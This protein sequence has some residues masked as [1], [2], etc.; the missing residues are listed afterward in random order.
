M[1]RFVGGFTV[2]LACVISAGVSAQ[3]TKV[4]TQSTVKADDAKAVTFTGCLQSGTEATSFVLAKAVPVSKTTS[5]ETAT[6]TTGTPTTTTTTTTTYALIPSETVELKSNVGQKVEVTGLVIPAATS[7]DDDAKIKAET[8]TKIENEK[9]PD[10][11][12]KE[13]AKADVARGATPQ[14][15]V[16]S[17]KPLGESCSM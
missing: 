12:V 16:I 14:L 10:T 7:K 17:I 3:D 5:T 6:G 4:K 15:K 13:T 9:I 2:A 1:K 8:K 11:K